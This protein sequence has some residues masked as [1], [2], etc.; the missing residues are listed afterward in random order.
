MNWPPIMVN[1]IFY[2]LT[3]V[4]YA[5]KPQKKSGTI[6]WK[7]MR[8]AGMHAIPKVRISTWQELSGR[9]GTNNPA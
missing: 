6:Y 8:A 9:S 2:G 1:W 7:S 4:G 3:A 5:L